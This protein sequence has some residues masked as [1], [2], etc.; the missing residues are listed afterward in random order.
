MDNIWQRGRDYV[1]ESIYPF[2]FNHLLYFVLFTV[3]TTYITDYFLNYKL[4]K[5][6]YFATVFVIII[7]V[8]NSGNHKEAAIDVF[9]LATI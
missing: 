5:W 3:V 1:V 4:F 6:I 7:T 8:Y 2:T 9:K